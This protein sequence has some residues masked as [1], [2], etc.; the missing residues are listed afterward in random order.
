MKYGWDIE[1][2]SKR[3][4]HLYV[5][6]QKDVWICRHSK[7]VYDMIYFDGIRV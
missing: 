1:R 5:L 3:R 7:C 4:M 6:Q 2:N